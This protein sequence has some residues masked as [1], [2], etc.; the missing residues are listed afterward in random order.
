MNLAVED[1]RLQNCESGIY[2]LPLNAQHCYTAPSAPPWP[3][4]ATG[5]RSRCPRVSRI[6]GFAF[7]IL[8]ATG[9]ARGDKPPALS[10]LA[11]D[12]VIVKGGPKLLGSILGR[13]ADGKAAIA[14]DRGWLKRTHP[15]FFDEAER[16]QAAEVRAAL[17]ELYERIVAWRKECEDVKELDFFLSR[18]LERVE[19]AQKALDDGKLEDGAPCLVLE[20][21]PAKIERVFVQPW[22]RKAIALT[23]W[24]EGL[25]DVE[26]R[27]ATSL[28]QELKKKQVALSDD[29]D[30]VLDFLPIR[31]QN[32]AE[33]AARRALVE[34]RYRT[35]LDFQGIGD[36]VARTGEGTKGFDAGRLLAGLVKSLGVGDLSD[37]LGSGP[38]AAAKKGAGNGQTEKWLA[39]ASE[40]AETE[41]LTGFRVTRVNQDVAAKR[42]AVETRFVARLDDGSWKTIWQRVETADASKVRADAEQQIQNDP[43]VRNALEL[44]KLIGAN[45]EEQIKLAIRFGA[46]TMEAQKEADSRFFQFRDRYLRQLDGPVMRVA[47]TAAPPHPVKAGRK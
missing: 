15:Q 42:V 26:T 24:R 35:P 23:G 17:T 14:V 39:S 41:G 46:A 21:P 32:D 38:E 28:L 13:E 40:T 5:G 19:K 3:P 34:Y 31:R 47:P 7:L 22:Q 37:L 45:G 10:E 11:V 43:Q 9:T 18:E 6:V 30:L 8:G 4:L 27:T 20:F 36:L 16:A 44:F 25:A 33:W 1:C 29:V 2:R 12:Q